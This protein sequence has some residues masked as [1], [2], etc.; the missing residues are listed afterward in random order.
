[1]VFCRKTHAAEGAV[2]EEY[3]RMLEVLKSGSA[4]DLEAEAFQNAT[5]PDGIGKYAGLGACSC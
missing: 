3:L 2:S 5:F 1:M 4:V